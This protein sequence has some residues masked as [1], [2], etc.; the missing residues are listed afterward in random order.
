MNLCSRQPEDDT[1]MLPSGTEIEVKP[2]ESCLWPN[3]MQVCPYSCPTCYTIPFHNKFRT[4]NTTTH[5]DTNSQLTRI[6]VV[7]SLSI[8]RFSSTRHWWAQK[9]TLKCH[10]IIRSSYKAPKRNRGNTFLLVLVY[11]LL[12][13]YLHSPNHLGTDS[14]VKYPSTERGKMAL[15]KFC[16]N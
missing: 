13:W 8:K 3:A 7:A 1:L 11:L 2:P 5:L 9:P 4:Q 12:W 10:S 16:I 14:C 15:G 6:F